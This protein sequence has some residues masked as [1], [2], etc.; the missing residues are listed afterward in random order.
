[1]LT[2]NMEEFLEKIK[3]GVIAEIKENIMKRDYYG[4]GV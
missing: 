4:K 3:D 1:M 2:E